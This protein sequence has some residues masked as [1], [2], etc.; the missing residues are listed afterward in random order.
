SQLGAPDG[1]SGPALPPASYS[2]ARRSRSRDRTISG[3]R[4]LTS[5]PYLAISL[6]RLEL[7]NE[8]SGLVGMQSGSPLAIRQFICAICISYSKSLTAR[9]PLIT[10]EIPLAAQKS[11]SRPWNRSILTLPHRLVALLTISAR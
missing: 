6:T 5:P 7:R 8:E 2:S 3:T 11:T 10:A 1:Y 4:P 9:N